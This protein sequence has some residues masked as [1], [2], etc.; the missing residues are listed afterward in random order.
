MGCTTAA[1]WRGDDAARAELAEDP[2]EEAV[3]AEA[4]E[5]VE[6]ESL[7]NPKMPCSGGWRHA[8]A[9]AWRCCCHEISRARARP[10]GLA[11]RPG[12]DGSAARSA[13]CRGGARDMSM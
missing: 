10:L 5:E 1:T 4:S 8:V 13:C 3:K 11:R 12:V 7:P 2:L 6:E 9:M